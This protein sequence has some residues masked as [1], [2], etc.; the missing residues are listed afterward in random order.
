MTAATIVVAVAV[1]LFCGLVY[2]AV[3]VRMI[4]GQTP[5]RASSVVIVITWPIGLVLMLGGMA[6]LWWR[7]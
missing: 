7:P 5:S 3:V 1:Y 6:G 4:G 2:A